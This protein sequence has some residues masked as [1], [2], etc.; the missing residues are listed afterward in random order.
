MARISLAQVREKIG[1]A[2]EEH[3]FDDAAALCRAVLEENPKNI[4]MHRRLGEALW[5]SGQPEEA[6]AE[7]ET[8]L[9]Y[10]PE[11][12][13]AYAGLGLI[14][15][16]AGD[17]EQAV[18][19]VSRAAELAPNS[20]EVRGELVRLYER[21]GGTENPK[22]KI[23]RPGLAR[24]YA[25]SDQPQR[26]ITEFRAV[27]ADQPDRLDARLAL[28]ELLWQEGQLAEAKAE[29]ETVLRYRADCLK[30]QLLL[31]V[32]ARSEG[33]EQNAQ[34]HFATAM[35][36]D[37]LNEVA[38]RLFGADSPLPP[39]DPLFDLP[40]YLL[41]AQPGAPVSA[42]DLDIELPDWLRE[43]PAQ[44]A[45]PPPAAPVPQASQPGEARPGESSVRLA[46]PA[47]EGSDESVPATAE[48]EQEP[49]WLE[50]LQR[51][52]AAARPGDGQVAAE[53]QAADTALAWQ[54]YQQDDLA[55]ALAIYQRLV[56]AEQQLDEA[57]Q[58]LT[59]IAADTED[60]DA[61]EL[62]GDAH[63][64]AGHY[65]AALD[66]YQRVLDKLR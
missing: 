39:A 65:R 59:V 30:A 43:E 5:E 18:A 27:L 48:S 49:S 54:S 26:A 46:A 17:L 38:E 34:E 4:H 55:G 41:G 22:L 19:L 51:P 37:P 16:Q 56:E 7:F 61:M 10:D 8:V 66:A 63:M 2:I 29:A 20:D 21:K 24:I 28:A 42:S 45:E 12:F 52:G 40:D 53:L 31:G 3:R 13:V 11:D 25:H 14:A 62:L 23:T 50:D 15:E 1:Q 60:L 35:L 9:S 57:I 6:R 58:A 33:R 44:A 32:I 36:I 64:R 47:P